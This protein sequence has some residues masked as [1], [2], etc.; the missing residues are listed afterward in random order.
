MSTTREDLTRKIKAL[1]AKAGD[2][3]VTEAEA[4]SFLAKAQELMLQHCISEYDLGCYKPQDFKCCVLWRGKQVPKFSHMW[5]ALLNTHLNVR[6]IEQRILGGGKQFTMY[7][8]HT[9]CEW[10]E[11]V[12]NFLIGKANQLWLTYRRYHPE[13]AEGDR[14]AYY[15]GL[16]QGI[17]EKLNEAKKPVGGCTALVVLNKDLDDGFREAFPNQQQSTHSVRI[18]SEDA[19]E[20][21]VR[22]G[23]DINLSKPLPGRSHGQARISCV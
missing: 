6:V 18:R 22:D 13:A 19:K 20:Q 14:G 2:D 9:N 23:R 15:C 8:T 3:S 10:A 7:G 5:V 16:Y 1:L 11:Y 21:G 17:D 4:A 12:F